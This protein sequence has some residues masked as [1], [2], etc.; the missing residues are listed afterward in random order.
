MKFLQVNYDRGLPNDDPAQ[1]EGNRKAAEM[2]AGVP[3][4]ISKIWVYDDESGRGGGMYLF[5]SDEAAHAFGDGPLEPS[6]S[7]QPGISNITKRYFD[8]EEGL[9]LVTHA[10]FGDQAAR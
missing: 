10:P 3:G 9:S 1:A 4:L 2:I 5:E 7:S 8:V 6:L